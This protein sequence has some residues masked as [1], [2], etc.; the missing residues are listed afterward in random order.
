VVIGFA[1]E[2]NDIEDNARAKLERK[3]ADFIVANDVSAETGI[4]GGK[5]N[6]VSIISREG[7][8]HWPDMDKAEVADRLVTLIAERLGG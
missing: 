7:V 2:T 8:A 3:G 1:A 4:M 5:R 6:Q